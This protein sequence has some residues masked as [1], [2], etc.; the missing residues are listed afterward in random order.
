MWELGTQEP[1]NK[2]HKNHRRMAAPEP[3][4]DRRPVRPTVTT[5]RYGDQRSNEKGPPASACVQSFGSTTNIFGLLGL[6]EIVIE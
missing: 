3:E 6:S 4:A 5:G 1:G 2:A